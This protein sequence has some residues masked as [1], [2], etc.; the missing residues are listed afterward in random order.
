MLK[1]LSSPSHAFSLQLF[2]GH[3]RVHQAHR[4][5]IDSVVLT[6]QK[7]DL[8]CLALANHPGQE[9]G[10]KT[11][12]EAANPRTRLAE[13]GILCRNGQVTEQVQYLTATDG[14][15]RHQGN[16]NFGETA[17]QALQIEHIQPW[18][19]LLIEVTTLPSHTL[20]TAGTEGPGPILG[21]SSPCQQHHTNAG[22]VAHPHKGVA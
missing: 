3:D 6:T 15:T 12:I 4:P 9:S 7:P 20:V 18:Q 16:H 13:A 8:P 19:P 5:G 11:S 22:I 17:D 21:R 14:I 2:Q 1:H 10:T